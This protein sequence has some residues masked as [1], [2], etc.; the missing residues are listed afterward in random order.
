MQNSGLM[1]M[2]MT[3][4]NCLYEIGDWRNWELR[5]FAPNWVH[6]GRLFTISIVYHI[7]MIN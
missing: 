7:A 5:R 3:I 6:T 4:I 1:V 2:T